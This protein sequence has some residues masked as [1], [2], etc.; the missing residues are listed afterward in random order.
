MKNYVTGSAPRLSA[1]ALIAALGIS[2]TVLAA[3]VYAGPTPDPATPG[4]F[5]FSGDVYTDPNRPLYGAA[6]LGC[7]ED[8]VNLENMRRVFVPGDI[9]SSIDGDVL[10]A[11][12]YKMTLEERDARVTGPEP[13]RSLLERDVEFCTGGRPFD[14]SPPAQWN[15]ETG[16]YEEQF[17]AP[18]N[19]ESS[20]V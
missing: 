20:D 7:N 4:A 3:L 18:R 19:L 6:A 2:T 1:R 9:D 13:G 8:V 11:G 15:V 10:R 14:G 12:Q 5:Q 16:E 17:L